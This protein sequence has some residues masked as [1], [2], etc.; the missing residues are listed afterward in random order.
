MEGR[1][2]ARWGPKQHQS[3]TPLQHLWPLLP[4]MS[5]MGGPA[6]R[7]ARLT[8]VGQDDM[9]GEPSELL[10]LAMVSESR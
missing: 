2:L 8:G 6:G 7:T 3:K 1:L 5:A 10:W 9:Q 4:W